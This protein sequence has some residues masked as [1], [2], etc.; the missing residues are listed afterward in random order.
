MQKLITYCSYIKLMLPENSKVWKKTSPK[1]IYVFKASLL[2]QYVSFHK[3]LHFIS[4]PVPANVLIL[5]Q[6]A[7]DKFYPILS[8]V[9]ITWLGSH[10]LLAVIE[11]SQKSFKFH[12]INSYCCLKWETVLVSWYR[13][14]IY[15]STRRPYLLLLQFPLVIVNERAVQTNW[16]NKIV[17][18]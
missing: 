4:R 9:E 12:V 15:K 10:L 7:V 2:K 5:S 6:T 17:K 18:P 16:V 11:T 3:T 13:Q 1:I 14:N 8:F